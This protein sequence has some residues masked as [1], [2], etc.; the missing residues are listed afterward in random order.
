MQR[1]VC[2]T[3]GVICATVLLA[4]PVARAWDDFGHMQVAAVAFKHLK[5]KTKAR[6]APLLRLNPR[7]ASWIVG[8][9]LHDRE[10]VAFIRAATWADSIKSDRR[11]KGGKADDQ[12]AP[13]AAQNIGYGDL[14]AHGYW[15]YVDLPFSPD[16]TPLVEPTA[17]NAATQIP[18]L[19]TALGA[20]ATSDEVRS[21]DLVWLLHLVGDIHQP[22]H[23][24]SRFDAAQTEGDR[25]GNKVA[26]SGNTQPTLC[27]DP[28][29]CPF[30]PAVELHAF[31]D[32][33]TG[34]SYA[35]APAEKAAAALPEP[36]PKQA[37]IADEQVWI[38]EGLALAQSAVY[39]A[40]I[41][42]GAG[43]FTITPE[44]QAAAAKLGKERI[45]LAG[46]RL[47]NL[48][49]SSLAGQ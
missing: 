40:P 32:D 10:R 5:Q 34:S 38:Q 47:A 7:Y 48:L 6:V 21:Y 27:D 22:L 18:L 39:V 33:I 24:V 46:R 25:G 43:P 12:S 8:A 20:A 23:C 1:V 2:G 42:T 35:T 4:A 31:Y 14:F 11:Y 26:I 28:R 37:A 29:Y 45:A 15:H 49:N 44:Y 41:G 19:R 3:L 30:G 13:T 16:G 9:S 36:D 17:P